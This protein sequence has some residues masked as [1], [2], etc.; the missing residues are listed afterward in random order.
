[1]NIGVFLKEYF[2]FVGCAFAGAYTGHILWKRRLPHME[3]AGFYL[4]IVSG[5]PIT[6]PVFLGSSIY[7]EMNPGTKFSF[8]IE[9]GSDKKKD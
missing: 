1:M 3:E 6:V 7:C 9:F 5:A 8:K 2:T 4:F